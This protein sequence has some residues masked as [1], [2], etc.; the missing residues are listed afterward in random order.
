LGR[1]TRGKFHEA[2]SRGWEPGVADVVSEW[3]RPVSVA[4]R[5]TD[6]NG[7]GRCAGSVCA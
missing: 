4:V 2:E 5:G 3:K 6:K 1:A 7:E